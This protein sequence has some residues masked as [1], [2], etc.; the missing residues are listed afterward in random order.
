M[1]GSPG[2][3]EVSPWAPTR[4]GSLRGEGA[5]EYVLQGPRS[6]K[7]AEKAVSDLYGVIAAS[8]GKIKRSMR[9]GVHVHV[10]CQE[11]TMRQ[12]GTVIAAYYAFEEV[13]TERFGEDRIGNLFCLRMV[14]AEYV[15][16]ALYRAFVDG[17]IS[18]LASDSVRYAAMNLNALG[19]YGSLEFR[20]METPAASPR[21]IHAWLRTLSKL[22]DSHRQFA[23]AQDLF[24]AFSAGGAE[25]AISIIFG[26]GPEAA[27]IR[28]I[29]DYEDKIQDGIRDSQ[30][31]VYST[32]WK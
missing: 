21:D 8:G 9:A 10:N 22:R 17:N 5:L 19:R 30:Y 3:Q 27:A 26:D 15:N 32:D 14:D 20:A 1:E 18:T 7:V 24:G 11:L 4:D 12:L 25:N 13:L 23:N 2:V 31:W 6:L 29:P 28:K 16:T